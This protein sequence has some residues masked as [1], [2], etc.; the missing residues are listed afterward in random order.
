MKRN[1]QWRSKPV[2][3]DRPQV[4]SSVLLLHV[5]L[6]P[7]PVGMWPLCPSVL[8]LAIDDTAI[9]EYEFYSPSLRD[10]AEEIIR[11]L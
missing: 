5:H 6:E 9:D 7:R 8:I 2:L 4:L 10:S 11:E 1:P 3:G